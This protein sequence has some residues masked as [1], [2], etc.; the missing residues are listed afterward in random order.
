[1]VMSSFGLQPAP[2]LKIFAVAGRNAWRAVVV[3]G[4]RLVDGEA[5]TQGPLLVHL[6][7]RT[8]GVGPGVMPVLLFGDGLNGKPAGAS[9]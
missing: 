7:G 8:N 5:G 2:K 1:M 4:R 6:V 3:V 9:F